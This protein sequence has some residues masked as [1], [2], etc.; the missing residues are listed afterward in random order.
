MADVNLME[1]AIAEYD[2]LCN[3]LNE[4][5]WRY[6]R[7]KSKL[8][9]ETMVQGEDIPI[10]YFIQIVPDVQLLQIYSHMPF[11][12]PE[13][14]RLEMSYIL[15]YINSKLVDGSFDFNID[16]GGLLFR[17]TSSFIDSEIGNLVFTYAIQIT[18]AVVDEYNDKLYEYAEGKITFEQL[19]EKI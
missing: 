1:K 8:S 4:M 17:V 16:N 19:M 3:T 11:T 5:G 6:E 13:D 14:K 15:N 2:L 9:V 12:V 18:A 10:R 7:D